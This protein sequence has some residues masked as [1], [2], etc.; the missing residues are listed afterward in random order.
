MRATRGGRQGNN[1]SGVVPEGQRRLAG[2]GAN[3]SERKP[4]ESRPIE[5][6]PAG[7]VEINARALFRRPFR[8]ETS[9]V[10]DTGGFA[11]LH[12]RLISGTPPTSHQPRLAFL[13]H[14]VAAISV[15]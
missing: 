12:H 8:G 14:S 11:S 6:A 13:I 10:I 4:P 2:G 3:V 5:P 15:M 1:R 7:A 9:F